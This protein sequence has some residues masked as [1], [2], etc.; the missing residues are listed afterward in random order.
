MVEVGDVGGVAG[1]AVVFA[2]FDQGVDLVVEEVLVPGV[3][4]YGGQVG[5]QQV[6]VG[7]D[8]DLQ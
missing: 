1:E 3:L 8:L 6:A 4:E 5:G 7:F 2:V